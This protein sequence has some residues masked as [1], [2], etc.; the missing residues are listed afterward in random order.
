MGDAAYG[1]MLAKLYE[2][3]NDLV[4][5]DPDH[6]IHEFMRQYRKGKPGKRRKKPK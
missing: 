2:Q 6:P 4:A 3:Y 5:D 1:E